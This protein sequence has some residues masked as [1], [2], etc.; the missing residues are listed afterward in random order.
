MMAGHWIR[1][2]KGLVRKPEVMQIARSL[3]ISQPEAAARL[4]LVWEW[5]D[6]VTEDGIILGADAST[7]DA[8]AGLDNFAHFMTKTQPKPWLILERHGLA[9][10]DFQRFNG[11][12]SKFR[13]LNA[14]RQRRNRDKLDK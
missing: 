1:W 8:I 2:E 4:M 12:S 6:D 13:A 7:I 9:F 10:P 5:A 3:S 14:E 11:K